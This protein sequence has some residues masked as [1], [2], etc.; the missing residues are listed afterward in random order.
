MIARLDDNQWIHFDNIT[1]AEENILWE[2]FS[3]SRPGRYV[4]PSQMANWDGVFRKYN[5]GQRRMARPFLSM[6]RGVCD[7]HNLP[8]SVRDLRPQWCYQAVD[9]ESIDENFLPGIK[10]D[11]Y[12]IDCI[13]KIAKVEC[14]I[15]DVPTGGGKGELIAGACKAIQCPTIVLA[16]Q[17]I[18]VK[19]L[20]ERLE[21]RDVAEEI[22]MFYAGKRPNGQMIVVGS[23][24]SLTPPSKPPAVPV[25]KAEESDK[26]FHRRMEQ[27]DKKFKAFKT[28]RKNA[29]ALVEYVRKSEMIIV[30]ESDKAVSDPWKNL[31]R[32]YFRGRRRYG[33]CLSGAV[34]VT[35]RYGS[36]RLDSFSDGEAVELLC[37]QDGRDI[38]GIGMV[39]ESGYKDLWEVSFD[40]DSRLETSG[41]HLVADN[42]GR[43]IRV[44]DIRPGQ[45]IQTQ[46]DCLVQKLISFVNAFGEGD[47]SSDL[48]DVAWPGLKFVRSDFNQA[49]V[50]AEVDHVL[51]LPI[52]L[53]CD[54]RVL[55]CEI[56]ALPVEKLKEQKL[57]GRGIVQQTPYSVQVVSGFEFGGK[58][59]STA[60]VSVGQGST[61]FLSHGRIVNGVPTE[62]LLKHLQSSL[63]LIGYLENDGATVAF[64]HGSLDS[65]DHVLQF[66]RVVNTVAT[67]ASLPP[68]LL[69]VERLTAISPQF[70]GFSGF[71]ML[72]D[73]KPVFHA[74]V[75]S[76]FFLASFHGPLPFFDDVRQALDTCWTQM[77]PEFSDLITWTI[78]RALIN[79]RTVVAANADDIMISGAAF[80]PFSFD[81]HR[82]SLL[83][84]VP[85]YLCRKDDQ[86][87]VG[88]VNTGRQ[89]PM[90]D[91]QDVNPASNFY[92]NSVLVHNS[93][94]PFDPDKPV[95]GMVMQEH[96]G[97]VIFR[98]TRENLTKLG[99][100]I[101]AEFI[102]LAYGLDG[103]I[104]EASAFDIAYNDHIVESMKFHRLIAGLCKK[105]KVD[106]MD[107]TLILVDREALGHK[108]VE[109]IRSAGLRVDFIF[110]KTPQRKRDMILRTFESREL[111]VLIGGKIIN[112]G[113]DLKGGCE[114]LIIATSGKLRSELTQ[115]I[116]RAL[117]RNRRGESRVYGFFFR[118]N[119]YLYDH[120]KIVLKAMVQAGYPTKVVFPGGS[121]DGTELIKS[122]F[123]IRRKLLIHTPKQPSLP[124]PTSGS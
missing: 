121:V 23:I 30:D 93:G 59:K 61:D 16:D 92:A 19:Q 89:I 41:D 115:K 122:R 90:Y 39:I 105:R 57:V 25:Q 124:M 2:A 12:Q 82:L 51:P 69:V 63:N 38:F 123:H 106:P 52:E 95:E 47:S 79:R 98:E 88:V 34:S 104:H 58:F 26:V 102:M 46:D 84:G 29:K 22:G 27:W 96:L 32:H 103:D 68:P 85:V 60:A 118:C 6:L 50:G 78:D 100:I 21:L 55:C 49:I 24:Q 113:L 114:N 36:R 13:K 37:R 117:R 70:G 108:L 54:S 56:D 116:G 86:R 53:V 74:V 5:R 65:L 10:L 35:T 75:A 99:R 15:I 73:G 9:P 71:L 43:Y 83:K 48:S 31:F 109:A 7:K 80:I 67:Q 112:R 1:D 76:N 107:G 4:D 64:Y 87:V 3:V 8:L 44:E 81:D 97:S 101:P 33:F 17:V 18:V 77:L 66:H 91:V 11:Q 120:S 119:R 62:S 28:R 72:R 94:T 42:L 45:I 40:D 110:G 111:D 14:G 20:K